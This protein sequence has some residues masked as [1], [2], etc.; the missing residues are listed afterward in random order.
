MKACE[1]T[2]GLSVYEHGEQ[3]RNKALELYNFLKTGEPLEGW[4]LPNWVTQYRKQ[5]FKD[6][7]PQNILEEYTL[8][9]DCGKPFCQS[10]GNQKFPDHA[11]KS[12]EIW[13]E[14]GGSRWAAELMKLDMVIHTM[15]VED[16]ESF[17]VYDWAPTLMIVGLAEIHANA[18]MFGGISSTSFKIKWKQI[19]RRGRVVCGKLYGQAK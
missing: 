16:I 13:K 3:V 15:K 4:L 11:R 14:V 7:V 2:K 6:Q 18:Q 8:Y 19:D 12:G 1:Q 17:V 5:L 10:I 9:H